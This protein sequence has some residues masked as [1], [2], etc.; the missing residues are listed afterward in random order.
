MAPP[1]G[2]RQRMTPLPGKDERQ[3]NMDMGDPKYKQLLR[4]LNTLSW[5]DNPTDYQRAEMARL[6][7]ELAAA[8][9]RG[10]I[11][12]MVDDYE[13]MRNAGDL[14]GAEW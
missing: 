5:L 3:T 14:G 13:L 8:E 12:R 2:T 1:L 4:R 11:A 10:P 7:A 9:M 6:D